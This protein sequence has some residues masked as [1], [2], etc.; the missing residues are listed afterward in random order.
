MGERTYLAVEIASGLPDD[1]RSEAELAAERALQRELEADDEARSALSAAVRARDVG[2]LR[3]AL[4]VM[5]ER[6]LD[7]DD[8]AIGA[9]RRLL[10][11]LEAAA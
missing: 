4:E 6:G 1:G 3:D 9:A 10:G 8:A 5:A 7:C 11:E 2:A